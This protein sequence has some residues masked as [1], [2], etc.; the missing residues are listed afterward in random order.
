MRTVRSKEDRAFLNVLLRDG[1]N[2][3]QLRQKE[4]CGENHWPANHNHS[5]ICNSLVFW[6]FKS[7]HIWWHP[8][9]TSNQEVNTDHHPE[10]II[11]TEWW[12]NVKHGVG[13]IGLTVILALEWASQS[14]DLKP[15]NHLQARIKKQEGPQSWLSYTS[16][17]RMNNIPGKYCEKTTPS[18]WAM[19]LT[20]AMSV[21]LIHLWP[22]ENI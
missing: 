7:P 1:K 21:P 4:L 9:H 8:D 19:P 18:I 16:L 6:P 20:L 12:T 5:Q 10:N 2:M 11:P 3:A 22:T 13:S 14:P 15:I 17:S